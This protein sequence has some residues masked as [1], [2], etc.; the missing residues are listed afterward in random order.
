MSSQSMM[1]FAEYML[2]R[3]KFLRDHCTHLESFRNPECLLP[4]P[5]LGQF[6]QR[7]AVNFDAI[8]SGE[9][10]SLSAMI[11]EGLTSDDDDVGTA[12]ATG[13]I[14]GLIHRAEDVET[15]WPRIEASLGPEARSYAD[16]YLNYDY[17]HSES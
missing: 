2:S 3:S 1:Q 7:I 9:W 14:E 12:V 5:M 13:L 16:A 10:A 4:I 8:P 6:G 15:L 17:G 11:E